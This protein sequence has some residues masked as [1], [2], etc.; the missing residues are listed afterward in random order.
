[1]SS[2]SSS[3]PIDPTSPLYLHPSDGTS[4]INV[5]KLQGASNYRPWRR[6]LEIALASKRKLGFVTGGVKRDENDKI[7]QESWDT[8]NNMVISWILGSV[9]ESI[10]KSVMI[11]T[12]AYQIWKHLESRYSITNGARKYSLNKQL[13]DT[14]QNGR[15]VSEYYTTM[16]AIWVELETLNILPPITQMTVEVNRFVQVLNAQKEELRLFQFLNGL[17]EEYG[18]QRSQIL[19][20]TELPSVDEACNMIQQEESQRELFK[21]GQNDTDVMAMHSKRNDTHCGN[22]GKRGHTTEK[23]WACRACG[24]PGHSYEKCW[25]VIGFPSKMSRQPKENRSKGKEVDK[26]NQKIVR[27]KSKMAAHA[28]TASD[29][30]QTSGIT[31]DQLEQLLKLLPTPSKGG[32]ENDSDDLEANYAE[33]AT[34][35]L[36]QSKSNAW[37]MDSGAT[38]HMSG[39]MEYLL[40]PK[41]ATRH[42]K[43]NLP[44]GGS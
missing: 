39:N 38:H 1:M 22:C 37:I 12:E 17:D 16:K 10:K 11:M 28:H 35:N 20:M 30:S 4:S 5:E 18:A 7:K 43:I 26:G 34:C 14:K 9:S 32:D 25:T 3:N 24:K 21:Q 2:G 19:M 6:S 13:Y 33:M 8:C 40:N 23:C 15:P 42:I 27:N 31:A 44:N 41:E 36:A 29:G